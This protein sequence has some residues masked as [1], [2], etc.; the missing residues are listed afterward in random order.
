MGLMTEQASHEET[1]PLDLEQVPDS[2]TRSKWGLFARKSLWCVRPVISSNSSNSSTVTNLRSEISDDNTS[3]PMVMARPPIR[4]A[5]P[6]LVPAAASCVLGVTHP[7]RTRRCPTSAKLRIAPYPAGRACERE[8]KHGSWFAA[9]SRVRSGPGEHARLSAQEIFF[10][11][12][13][14]WDPRLSRRRRGRRRCLAPPP[15]GAS[16]VSFPPQPSRKARCAL[17]PCR[18][19]HLRAPLRS[20]VLDERVVVAC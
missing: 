14:A 7:Q 9:I 10:D 5:P 16:A 8:I 11:D 20:R 13:S 2:G 15:F 1:S 17:L 18:A 6:I 3:P 12:A 19:P 4:T